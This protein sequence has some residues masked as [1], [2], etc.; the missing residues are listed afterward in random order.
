MLSEQTAGK[1]QGFEQSSARKHGRPRKEPGLS[2]LI[3]QPQSV[4]RKRASVDGSTHCLDPLLPSEVGL[5]TAACAEFAGRQ[6]FGDRLR[7]NTVTLSVSS[8]ASRR[9]YNVS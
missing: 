7:F 6:G 2:V 5:A 8:A 3:D 1:I 9:T 4:P